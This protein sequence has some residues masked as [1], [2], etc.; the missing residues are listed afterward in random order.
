MSKPLGGTDSTVILF[1]PAGT[2]SN[3]NN[4]FLIG[5]SGLTNL[6]NIFGITGPTGPQGPPG[7]ISII[8]TSGIQL[9]IGETGP[10]GLRGDT[11]AQGIQG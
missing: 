10:Q 11:G 3:Q 7:N 5:N 6:S 4:N 9:L 1:G 8:D 2:T